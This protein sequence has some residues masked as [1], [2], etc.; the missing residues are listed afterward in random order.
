MSDLFDEQYAQN[1]KAQA[2]LAD[3]I[4][5]TKLSEFV[6]Q[7]HFLAKDKPVFRPKK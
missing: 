7:K 5:P 2:P 6:G 3:R 4:R 1:L